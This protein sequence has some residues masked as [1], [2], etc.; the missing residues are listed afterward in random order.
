MSRAAILRIPIVQLPTLLGFPD[1]VGVLAVWTDPDRACAVLHLAGDGLPSS[2][3]HPPTSTAVLPRIEIGELV[4]SQ[5]EAN[6]A[7]MAAEDGYLLAA[8]SQMVGCC[9]GRLASLAIQNGVPRE[10]V[11]QE[12]ETLQTAFACLA[13]MVE[14]TIERRVQIAAKQKEQN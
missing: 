3:E 4:E 5:Q 8:P 6:P 12:L 14:H 10:N 11:E 7:G 1:R 2:A 13:R 9:A